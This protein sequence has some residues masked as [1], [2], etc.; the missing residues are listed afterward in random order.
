MNELDELDAELALEEMEDL[1]NANVAPIAA[2]A[3]PAPAP[4]A[5]HTEEA[6]QENK[7]ADLMAL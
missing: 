6:K 4:V 5:A 7:L 2:A 1:P 3:M